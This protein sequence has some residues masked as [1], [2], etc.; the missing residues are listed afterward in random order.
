MSILK[1]C[2]SEVVA[3]V[4][5]VKAWV[6]GELHRNEVAQVRQELYAEINALKLEL[7]AVN[8]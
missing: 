1:K 2:V 4:R 3:E 5:Q 7:E 8:R 6:T